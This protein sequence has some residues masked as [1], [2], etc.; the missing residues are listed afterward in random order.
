MSN[1][2]NQLLHQWRRIRELFRTDSL[3]RNAVFLMSSTAIMSV[4]G[5]VFWIFVAHLYS[6]EQIGV[7]SALISITLL[8]SNLSFLGLGSGFLRF[9]PGSAKPSRDINA[10]LIMTQR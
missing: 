7:A 3:F 9:L 4:L 5:F 1:L 6:P 10:G 2:V 8:I